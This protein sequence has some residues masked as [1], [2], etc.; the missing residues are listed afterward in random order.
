MKFANRFVQELADL[1]AQ[2]PEQET[3]LFNP[4]ATDE[5]IDAF[6]AAINLPL[7]DSFYE[8]YRW[9]D[10]SKSEDYHYADLEHGRYM[11]PLKHILGEKDMWDDHQQKGVFYKWEDGA[12]WDSAWVPF[13]RIDYWYLRVLDTKGSFGGKAGQ[14]LDFDYKSA[15]GRGITNESFDKWLE[16]IIAKYKAGLLFS[17]MSEIG[18]DEHQKIFAIQHAVNGEYPFVAELWQ[19]RRKTHAPNPHYPKMVDAI[20]KGEQER[21][22]ALLQQGLVDIDEID[23]AEKDVL[24]PLLLAVETQ[25]WEIAVM[26]VKKGANLELKDAYGFSA[27]TKAL[28]YYGDYGPNKYSM[29]LDYITALM[30]RDFPVNFDHLLRGAIASRDLSTTEFSLKHGANANGFEQFS[31]PYTHIHKAVVS[32][33]FLI[34]KLLIKHGADVNSR[35]REGHTALELINQEPLSSRPYYTPIR[36]LLIKHGAKTNG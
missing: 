29:S 36:K 34:V 18:Y 33:Q 24:T 3:T 22:E 19:R 26:L 6:K 35:N 12:Y 17:E 9:H 11:L 14:I 2:N 4:G 31:V 25:H 23:E 1:F 32:S 10:G 7:P 5:E 16:T 28:S 27:F 15:E 8:F 30:E 20:C 21:V 13:M